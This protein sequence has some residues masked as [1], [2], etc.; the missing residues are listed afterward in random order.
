MVFLNLDYLNCEKLR[1]TT[2][3]IHAAVIDDAAFSQH[4]HLCLD[5]LVIHSNKSNK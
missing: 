1:A 3:D 2:R 4:A 5:S